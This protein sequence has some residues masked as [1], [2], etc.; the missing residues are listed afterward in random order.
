M[1]PDSDSD[2]GSDS[3]TSTSSSIDEDHVNSRLTPYWP[4][5]RYVM[6]SRGFRLDTVHDVKE[7]YR[8]HG[9]H[10]PGYSRACRNIDDDQ[11]CRD[12]GLVI[13]FSEI[14]HVVLMLSVAWLFV[15][16]FSNFGRNK[17]SRQSCTS[18]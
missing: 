1:Y 9:R 7:F 11:L 13:I 8:C 16:G 10:L 18:L 6:E 17:S 15:P 14:C 3:T 4:A 5:Y 2:S 12:D